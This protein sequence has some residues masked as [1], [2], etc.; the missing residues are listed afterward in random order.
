MK[1]FEKYFK[2]VE[3]KKES[4]KYNKTSRIDRFV[5]LAEALCS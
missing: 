1:N 3:A 2:A 5:T 4:H